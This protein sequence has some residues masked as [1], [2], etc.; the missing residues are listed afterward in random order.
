MPARSY[1]YSS[2][3]DLRRPSSWRARAPELALGAAP[4]AAAAVAAA[5]SPAPDAAAAAASAP[6]AAAAATGS[7]LARR[8]ERKELVAPPACAAIRSSSITPSRV[9]AYMS[10][11]W[12]KAKRVLIFLLR[13]VSK[14][15]TMRLKWSISVSG[16]CPSTWRFSSC[17]GVSGA[18]SHLYSDRVSHSIEPRRASYTSLLL[19]TVSGRW[20]KTVRFSRIHWN[21]GQ[22]IWSTVVPV[23][24]SRTRL[25][26]LE[27]LRDS[28]T[29]FKKALT[30]SSA[31]C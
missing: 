18:A 10:S 9:K 30:N 27:P 6:M 19:A 8:A 15:N 3:G 16:S 4:S 31:S 29:L 13:K 26:C 23:K 7:P 28:D 24:Q 22:H 20:W 14:S 5:A 1:K 11:S 12:G 2:D 25:C 17:V 21:S